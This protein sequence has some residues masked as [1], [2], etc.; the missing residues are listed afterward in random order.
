[1]SSYTF[2]NERKDFDPIRMNFIFWEVDSRFG[3][4]WQIPYES[5][6]RALDTSLIENYYDAIKDIAMR[7]KACQVGHNITSTP[8]N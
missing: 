8:Q 3:L 1:M 2:D 5:I 6:R 4:R 7:E